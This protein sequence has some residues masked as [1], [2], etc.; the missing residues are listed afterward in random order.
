MD[1]DGTLTDGKICMGELGEI[2][3]VF[4]IKD[5]YGIHYMLPKYGMTPVVIT[6]RVSK[7]VENRCIELGIEHIYQGV[8]DKESILRKLLK[9]N[10]INYSEVVYVGDDLNDLPAMSAVKSKGGLVACPTDAVSEVK[11]TADFIASKCGGDG[12]V[13]EIIE[14]IISKCTDIV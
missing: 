2:S 12:A 7:I 9:Y 10:D 3:K 13:R 11:E 6:G 1:V 5:G 4:D 14:W 8:S